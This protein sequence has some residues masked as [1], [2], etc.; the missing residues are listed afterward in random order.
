MRG[1]TSHYIM[2][3]FDFVRYISAGNDA[4]VADFQQRG[5][6]F[7]CQPC[8]RPYSQVWW[9]GFLLGYQ[10]RCLDCRAKL[11]L[12]K[13]S[14][15][16]GL[17]MPLEKAYGL[18][19]F[20]SYSYETPVNKAVDHLSASSATVF[21]WYQYFRDICSWNLT[22]TLTW[23]GSVGRIVQ[24]DESIMMKAKYNRGH[25]LTA[26]VRWV[27]G[28]YDPTDKV[29]H[30]QLVDQR[31]AAILLPIILKPCQTN[32]R[33]MGSWVQWDSCIKPSITASILRIL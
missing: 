22:T 33:L 8:G 11:S 27:F 9:K 5:Q 19:Y 10:L 23:L 4:M 13:D 3:I 6:T 12:S 21:Q 28:V 1:I 26:P 14:L 25:Q 29:G 20:W 7:Q 2:S 30:I 15:F 31:N 24:I 18:M 17:R 32:G 16:E